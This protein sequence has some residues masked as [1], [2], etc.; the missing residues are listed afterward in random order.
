MLSGVHSQ[1]LE[2]LKHRLRQDEQGQIVA[3]CM[4]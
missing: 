2:R 3:F 4:E 1:G